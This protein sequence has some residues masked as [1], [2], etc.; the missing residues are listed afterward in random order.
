MKSKIVRIGNSKCIRI[1]K[2]LLAQAGLKGEVEITAED[3][4]VVI[5]PLK[6]PGA[7]WAVA[8]S[9]MARRGDDAPIDLIR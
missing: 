4:S 5:R 1:P 8:F 7:G 6:T 2:R 9:E 3:G